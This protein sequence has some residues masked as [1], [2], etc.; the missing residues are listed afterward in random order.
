[1]VTSVRALRVRTGGLPC[2]YVTG[3]AQGSRKINHAVRD[4]LPELLLRC[5]IL[6]QCGSADLEEMNDVAGALPYTIRGRYVVRQFVERDEIGDAYA[7]A[8]VVI[9]RAGA[10]TVCELAALGKPS[11]LIPLEPSSKGEQLR[12]AQRLVDAGGAVVVRQG[13]LSPETLI[14]A[15]MPMLRDPEARANRGVQASALATPN[16]TKDVVDAL[17]ALAETMPTR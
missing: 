11:V 8:D 12:N 5:R 17:L 7:L 10:G 15:V 6:H 13:A 9:G 16:A 2:V 3:G 1:V 14:E 4:A